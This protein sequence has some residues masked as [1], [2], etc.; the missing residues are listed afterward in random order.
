MCFSAASM[1][2]ARQRIAVVKA[3]IHTAWAG[4]IPGAS[5]QLCGHVSALSVVRKP[6]WVRTHFEAKSPG[7]NARTSAAA[8]MPPV[9]CATQNSTKRTGSTS[10]E[11]IARTSTPTS[12]GSARGSRK[13]QKS[14]RSVPLCIFH[15]W[16]APTR[17]SSQHTRATSASASGPRSSGHER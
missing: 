3:S 7:V 4:L 9:S 8:A 6:G 16:I 17:P 12:H 13:Q 11:P 14:R 2:T 15:R 5:T 1:S 10:H